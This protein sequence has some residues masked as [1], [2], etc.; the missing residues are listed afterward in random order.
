LL[1]QKLIF[2]KVKDIRYWS[3]ASQL[4]GPGTLQRKHYGKQTPRYL[5]LMEK[6]LTLCNRDATKLG[7]RRTKVW[8]FAAN[9]CLAHVT[10]GLVRHEGRA[11]GQCHIWSVRRRMRLADSYVTQ[12]RWESG[13]MRFYECQSGVTNA[14]VVCEQ[15]FPARQFLGQKCWSTKMY[16]LHRGKSYFDS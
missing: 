5:T 8:R 3:Q 9:M 7:H 6:F 14:W 13:R 16:V 2:D 12:Q 11:V 15:R 1:I 4:K 10:G